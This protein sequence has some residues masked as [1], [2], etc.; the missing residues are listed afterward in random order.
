MGFLYIAPD[1]REHVIPT[2]SGGEAD[3]YWGYDGRLDFMTTA[4]KYD[5]ATQNFALFDGLQCAIEFQEKIGFE[6][7]EQRVL[8]LTSMLREGLKALA[9]GHFHFLTPPN[10]LTGLTTIKL[11]HMDYKEFYNKMWEKRKVRTR[12]VP[13]GGLEASRFSVHIYTS[14]ADVAAF[15]E[16]AKSTLA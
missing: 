11:E 14:E 10:S 4:S 9:P 2:W 1:F 7:I 8:H 15:L 3:K 16:V 5:F 13:E 6:K 12:I